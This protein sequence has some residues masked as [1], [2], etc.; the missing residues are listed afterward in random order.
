METTFIQDYLEFNSGNECSRKFH[1]WTAFS[2]LAAAAGKRVFI[3]HGYFLVHPN[4]YVCLVAD[5]GGR[6][7]SAKDIGRDLFTEALPDYPI[8]AS[9]QSR[10]DI[11]KRMASDELER[12]YTDHEGVQITW[13]P[14]IFFV[15]ELKNFLSINPA[16]MIDFLTDIYDRRAFDASTIKHG[17][18]TIHNPCVNILACETP[19]W[20][21]DKLKMNIISGGFSRRMLYVYETEEAQRIAFP[22][23]TKEGFAARQRCLLHLQKVSKTVGVFQWTP[24][25]KKWFS[26]WYLGL[27]F[28]DDEV[29]AGYY[30]SKH[31]MLLKLVQLLALAEK[32]IK[33]TITPELLEEGAAHLEVIETN[34]PKLSVAAGRNEL[35]VPQQALLMLLE[36]N[37][38]MML[39]KDLLRMTGKD[40]GPM[41][42]LSVMRFL[43]ETDQIVKDRDGQKM[44]I[45]LPARYVQWVKDRTPKTQSQT[46]S[47]SQ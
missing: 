14:I 22:T 17:L 44:T 45:F 9:V 20:I 26:D 3:N 31:V 10:E 39:E 12:V 16:G 18:Q 33:L 37:G 41:E 35:A 23:P 40:L 30:R 29:M 46:P 21:I 8:G 25:A 32:T 28:P 38:G 27:K 6:K 34:M 4:I 15:N 42:Q 24:E 1:M 36:K 19:K 11:V 47:P 2:L 43:S 7:S 5:Q 13:K